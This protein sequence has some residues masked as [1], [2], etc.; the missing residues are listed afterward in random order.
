MLGRSNGCSRGWGRLVEIDQ[1]AATSV[2]KVRAHFKGGISDVELFQ[3]FLDSDTEI[4]LQWVV[5]YDDIVPAA[6]EL[7]RSYTEASSSIHPKL[8]AWQFRALQGRWLSLCSF[9]GA[10]GQ[11]WWCLLTGVRGLCSHVGLSAKGACK[12]LQLD[13]SNNSDVWLIRF[14]GLNVWA[15]LQKQTWHPTPNSANFGNN[16]HCVVISSVVRT[17][18]AHSSF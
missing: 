6:V 7:H 14:I 17:A 13:A 5:K 12:D 16:L 18:M 8:H 3:F 15:P 10:S 1:P 2:A 11:I 4:W 9:H